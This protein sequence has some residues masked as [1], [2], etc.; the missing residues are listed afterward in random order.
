MYI[1]M[2]EELG[3]P[4]SESGNQMSGEGYTIRIYS[5]VLKFS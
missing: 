5:D 3:I 4:S 2:A 1:S